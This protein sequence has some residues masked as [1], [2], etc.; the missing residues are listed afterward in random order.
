MNDEQFENQLRQV[1]LDMPDSEVKRRLM[2]LALSK[3]RPRRRGRMLRW[4]L[5]AAAG[6]LILINVGFER[7]H[8]RYITALT[9][10]PAIA[11][12]M[13]GAAYAAGLEQ[14]QEM[15][16]EILGENGNS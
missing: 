16:S 10:P 9:G 8:Q 2:R 11:R 15:M 4:A 6:L 7:G 5:A 13:P 1:P 14:R 3:A 12:P